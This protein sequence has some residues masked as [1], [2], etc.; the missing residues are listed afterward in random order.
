MAW[1]GYGT[2]RWKRLRAA[3]L[4]R[5]GYLCRENL[6][7]GRRVE[8]TYVHHVWPVEDYPEYAWC[9]WNLIALTKASHGAMHDRLTHKLTPLGEAW[10]LR[11]S[12]P[13]PLP[14]LGRGA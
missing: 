2:A 6:R 12:P 9:L 1:T 11:V 13:S 4:R 5:D 10:R 7:Y 8:A 3:A 14:P